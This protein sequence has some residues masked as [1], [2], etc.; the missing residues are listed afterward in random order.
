MSNRVTEV[1]PTAHSRLALWQAVWVIARRDFLAVLFSRAFLFFLLGPLFPILVGGLAGGIGGEVQRQ[2]A[3]THIGVAMADED[4]ERIFTAKSNLAGDIGQLL[5]PMTRVE[6]DETTGEFATTRELLADEDRNLAAILSGT[7]AD[8]VL[9]GPPGQISRVTPSVKLIVAEAAGQANTAF[10]AISMDEIRNSSTAANVRT[11]R[12]RTAQASQMLL[13]LLTMLLAGMVLSNLVEEKANKIIEILAAAIP[14]DALFLGKLFAMLGV[15]LV[16]IA[17]WGGV[18]VGLWA[19]VGEAVT[20]VTSQD[21][22]DLPTPALGWAGFL[23]LGL[24]YFTMAY[25]LLGSLFLAIGGM[26]ATV[27]EVQTL[28]MPVTLVQLLV[29]FFAASA[30]P[31]LGTNYEL[32]ATIFPLSSPFAMLARAALVDTLWPHVLA[33]AW[34]ALWVGITIKL[35]AALFRKRVLKSGGAGTEKKR[36][37]WRKRAAA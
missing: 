28:S 16:G 22:S 24:A 17:V 19:A 21:M 15:S 18:I 27:R 33:L 8:P 34:Q 1:S 35:G 30:I 25:L 37:W 29:F 14:L 3:A 12:I 6:V 11:D 13:F 23:A 32:A 7:V 10:P 36:R 20:Q 5:P 26:A 9:T 31:F 2:S 4:F